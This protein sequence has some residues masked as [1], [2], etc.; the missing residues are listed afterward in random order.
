MSG[1]QAADLPVKAKKPAVEYVKICSLYGA[2][3]YYIPGTDTCLKIGGFVRVDMVFGPSANPNESLNESADW[4]DRATRKYNTRARAFATFDARTQTSYGTLRSYFNV[5]ATIDGFGAESG[6][7]GPAQTPYTYRAFI[8]LA[9]FTWGLTDSIFDVYNAT[10]LHLNYVAAT[11]GSIGATGIWQWR[12]TAQFGG[13]V[14]LALAIEEPNR[15]DKAVWD[16]FSLV[17]GAGVNRTRGPRY[18]DFLASLGANGAWGTA[19]IG[20]A[21]RDASA[22]YY[23]GVRAFGSPGDEIG[24]AAMAGA[25]VRVPGLPGDTFGVQVVYA[26]GA[27]GYVSGNTPGSIFTTTKGSKDTYGWVT[28]GVFGGPGTSI[29]LT[30]AWGVEI[31]YEHAWTPTLKTSLA[32]G[33]IEY[34][35]NSTATGYICGGLVAFGCN[36]DFALWNIGSRT[37]WNP[38]PNLSLGV[39]VMYTHIESATFG[40][41]GGVAFTGPR[42]NPT[43]DAD[44]WTGLIRVQRVFWP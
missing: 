4:D 15:R 9:G 10:P 43:D 17:T 31:G 40:S 1:A 16:N 23:D 44:I 41:F 28:D 8:Q 2:G 22:T 38:V 29:E 37:T 14:F 33:Y 32:G 19:A 20:I 25:F 18:P 34:D 11:N 13:G 36:P 30:T 12:Y 21:I 39:D 26:E 27:T 3:Y 6:S 35:Y 7:I 24:W 5:G 42:G